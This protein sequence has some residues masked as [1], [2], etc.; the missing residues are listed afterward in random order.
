MEMKTIYSGI[1]AD[2]RE[3]EDTL[4]TN[5]DQFEKFV[6]AIAKS[7]IVY[8]SIPGKKGKPSANSVPNTSDYFLNLKAKIDFSKFNV[9]VI[10]CA[11]IKEVKIENKVFQS[12]F[13]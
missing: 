9:I 8:K 5:Q 10:V 3:M 6:F 4:I 12:L 13:R 1:K 7:F 11:G 2:D